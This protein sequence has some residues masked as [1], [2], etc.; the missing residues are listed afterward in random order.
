MIGS[1]AWTPQRPARPHARLSRAASPLCARCTKREASGAAH[2]LRRGCRRWSGGFQWR[3]S[4]GILADIFYQDFLGYPGFSAGRGD[5][6][7]G[8]ARRGG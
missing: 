1:H 4:D 7:A 5:D 3:R 8:G 6:S 2:V